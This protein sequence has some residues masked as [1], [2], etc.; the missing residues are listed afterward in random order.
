MEVNND[1]VGLSELLDQ[2]SLPAAKRSEV[3]ATVTKAIKKVEARAEATAEEKAK[4]KLRV[5]VS[6]AILIFFGVSYWFAY[7]FITKILATEN[8]LIAAKLLD[9][10]DRSING[11]TVAA[12]IA[13]TVTQTGL[14]LYAVTKYL[15]GSAPEKSINSAAG[16]PTNT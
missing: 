6:I 12:L 2:A 14:A 1:F 7:E 5:G 10:K 8:A 13:A 4:I 16:A 3:E 15:F 9:A 11:N